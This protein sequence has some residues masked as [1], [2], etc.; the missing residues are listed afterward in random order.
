MWRIATSGV[1]LANNLANPKIL[2]A[3]VEALVLVRERQVEIGLGACRFTISGIIRDAQHVPQFVSRDDIA[4][5]PD[6][7]RRAH[8]YAGYS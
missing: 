3:S 5:A 6:R 2:T 7:I 1:D 8:S 4:L